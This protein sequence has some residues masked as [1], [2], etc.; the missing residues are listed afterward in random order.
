MG[1][2][3]FKLLGAIGAWVGWQLLPLVILL[4]A[5]VG[6]I[7]GIALIVFGGRSSQT[8]IPFGPYLA[9]AGWIALLW[10]DRIVTAYSALFV[11]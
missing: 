5:V 1:Y 3:D 9:A 10:G 2:G 8:A 11:P 4:S 6:S 7:V